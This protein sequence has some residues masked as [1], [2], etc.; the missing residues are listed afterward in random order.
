MRDPDVRRR[1]PKNTV[2]NAL[3]RHFALLLRLARAGGGGGDAAAAAAGAAAA[4]G[5]QGQALGVEGLAAWLRD[6]CCAVLGIAAPGG[7]GGGAAGPAGGAGSEVEGA[8]EGLTAALLMLPVRPPRRPRDA[9]PPCPHCALRPGP[10]CTRAR[11]PAPRRRRAP[12]LL[13]GPSKRPSPLPLPQP[14]QSGEVEAEAA[15]LAYR[16]LAE[17]LGGRPAAPPPYQP[18]SG[19]AWWPRLGRG[20]VRPGMALLPPLSARRPP[21]CAVWGGTARSGH[22]GASPLPRARRRP[23]AR[24]AGPQPLRRVHR[25]GARARGPRAA[26]GGAH[27]ARAAGRRRPGCE[28]ARGSCRAIAW[29]WGPGRCLCFWGAAAGRRIWAARDGAS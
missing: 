23:P 22:V 6:E 17:L 11:A 8:L 24:P 3:L 5:Q 19:P 13:A 1:S 28:R 18:H 12:P 14:G 21:P 7:A 16:Q 9:P 27:A 10:A 29:D 15:R 20:P 2:R 25:G 26:R 4:E